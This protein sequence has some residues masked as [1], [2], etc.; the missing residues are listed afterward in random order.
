M[1]HEQQKNE[2]PKTF[3]WYLDKILMVV[4]A[5]FLMTGVVIWI[6]STENDNITMM[7][8][9]VAMIPGTGL[10]ITPNIVLLAVKDSKDWKSRSF[11]DRRGRSFN[12]QLHREDFFFKM[13]NPSRFHS[14]IVLGVVRE[15]ILNSGGMMIL[16]SCIIIGSIM[17]LIL[18]MDRYH[19]GAYLFIFIIV[20]FLILI[21]SYNITCSVCRIRTVLRREYS[22]YHAV[23]SKVDWLD[24]YITGEKG[25]VY[26]FGYCRCL[27]V[28][29]KEI[30]DTNVVLVFVPDEVY[31]L[32]YY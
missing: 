30:H 1:K 11:K 24:M 14:K 10:L 25:N 21:L 12:N 8:I 23:V 31:L 26:K 27:G 6:V 19:A 3:K 4:T 17:L 32:P 28:R 13:E 7:F 29:A 16:I 15:A 20:V 5:A 2:K 22:V 9:S 18:G